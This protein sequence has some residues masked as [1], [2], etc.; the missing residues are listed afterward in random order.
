MSILLDWIESRTGL[1]GALLRAADV[2]L[3]DGPR[4]RYAV[5]F[6]LVVLLAVL[7]ITGVALMTVYAPGVHTAWSSVFYLQEVLPWGRLVRGVH[8]FASH[9]AVALFGIHL[10]LTA[11]AAGY[12]RPREVSWWLGLGLG[13]LVVAF[14]ITGL[15][16]AWDQRGYWSSR[17]ETGIAASLPLVGPRVH[18][19]LL[20]GS[21]YGALTLTRFYT[22]HV[23]VLPVL[24]GLVLYAQSALV[25]RHGLGDP[26]P[27]ARPEAPAVSWWPSQGA[28]N[29]TLSFVV[30]AVVTWMARRWGA[31][32]A[33][34]ADAA[35]QYPAVPLW[36]FMPLSQLLK[37][38][39]PRGQIWA[40]VVA[41]GVLVT[42]L[43]A[44]P[45]LD[46]AGAAW[47]RALC[48]L[49][50]GIAALG[51]G[52]LGRG[53]QRTTRQPA[54]VARV[55]AAEVRAV[56]ARVLARQGIPVEGPLELVRNDPEVRPRELFAQHCGTCHAVRGV[57]EETRGPRL[58]GFGSRGWARAFLVW[59]DAPHFMGTTE[60]HDMPPQGRRLR[61][62][63]LR[64]V[65]EWLYSRGVE[66]GEAPADATLVAQ[67]EALYRRR[68]TTCHQGE[69]DQSASEPED[70]DAPNLDRWGSRAYIQAQ[71]L[72]PGG[73]ENYGTR[74]HMPRFG[75]RLSARELVMVIDYVRRLRTHEPPAVV[76]PVEE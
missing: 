57:S 10:A 30:V 72:D 23:A 48:L 60:I 1:P 26:A 20:G 47:R 37:V 62:E 58:D 5:A 29:L 66:P 17:V 64:A 28:R 13:G 32:L 35:S 8:Y 69:G 36:F 50:L 68:C 15:P 56:R 9:A 63:G 31:P 38:A 22:L 44:L 55:Q 67:G 43:V 40:A 51:A 18:R 59:P 41:P 74:N 70:R 12:R 4:W 21:H 46:R 71:M 11:L 49:P 76:E 39:G 16:L 53:L 61:E 42:Y 33:A 52:L 73:R 45:W 65:S 24:L 54:F 34:P 7:G 75:D 6:A 14:V 19:L 3:H 25:R 2:T 27:E